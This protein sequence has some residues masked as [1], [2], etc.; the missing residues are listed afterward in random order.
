MMIPG[1]NKMHN[2]YNY[3]IHLALTGAIRDFNI[4]ELSGTLIALVK[5]EKF[6]L[7]CRL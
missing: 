1:Y 6:V 4:K 5:N 3:H 2:L 7:L